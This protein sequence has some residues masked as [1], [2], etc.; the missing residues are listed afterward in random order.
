M[1]TI[2]EQE[3]PLFDN[4]DISLSDETE[5]QVIFFNCNFA[6]HTFSL[7]TR[8]MPTSFAHGQIGRLH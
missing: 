7:F 4:V 6:N 3:P 2:G 8:I 1:E 5:V